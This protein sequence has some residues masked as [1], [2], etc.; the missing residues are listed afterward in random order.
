[1]PSPV[2]VPDTDIVLASSDQRSPLDAVTGRCASPSCQGRTEPVSTLGVC[3]R[4]AHPS[5]YGD[6]AMSSA[7]DDIHGHPLN[8]PDQPEQDH[9]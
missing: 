3:A 9:E 1:M 7:F 4:C 5:A 2:V 6:N 8:L